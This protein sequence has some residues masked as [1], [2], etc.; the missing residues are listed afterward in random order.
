MFRFPAPILNIVAWYSLPVHSWA[1][2]GCQYSNLPPGYAY[3]PFLF[4]AG[5]DTIAFLLC[6]AKVRIREAFD[7]EKKLTLSA[8]F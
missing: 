7:K 6:T 4:Q 8:S 3:L 5:F 2:S 1:G